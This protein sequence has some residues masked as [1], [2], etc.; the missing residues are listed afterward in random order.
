MTQARSQLTRGY[1]I[2][3][4]SAVILSTTAI[5]IR[6]L[7]QTYQLPALVLAGCLLVVGARAEAA[8]VAV[9]CLTLC[10]VLV[11]GT[12][13]PF[14]ATLNQVAGRQGGTGGGIMN[15]GSN[16]GGMI[17]PVLTPWLAA[18]IGWSAALSGTAVLALLAGLTGTGPGGAVLSVQAAPSGTPADLQISS[19]QIG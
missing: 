18:R 12:E 16:L 1:S 4:L 8:W 9:A 19:L 6:Y 17:S 10:T 5:F 7:T 13:G 3:L 11:I 14:W 15:F 2:A